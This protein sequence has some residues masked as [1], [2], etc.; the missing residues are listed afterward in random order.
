MHDLPV[1]HPH[2]AEV[3]L[4]DG[5]FRCIHALIELRVQRGHFQMAEFEFNWGVHQ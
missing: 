2:A 4:L 3:L 5:Y 1:H